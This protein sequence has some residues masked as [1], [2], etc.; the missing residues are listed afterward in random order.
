MASGQPISLVKFAGIREGKHILSKGALRWSSPELFQGPF[1]LRYDQGLEFSNKELLKQVLKT[2]A[3][4]VFARD[5]PTPG[6][7]D[8]PFSKLIRRWRTEDRFNS[9]EEVEE[10]LSNIVGNMVD[11]QLEETQELVQ[12]WSYLISH[13][14]VLSLLEKHQEIDFWEKYADN[15]RGIAIRFRCD[16]ENSSLANPQRAEYGVKRPQITTLKE[17][18]N[19]LIGQERKVEESTLHEKLLMRSKSK[20][21]EKE[22]VCHK[23]LTEAEFEEEQAAHGD[24]D[25][26]KWYQEVKFTA[27]E[28]SAVYFGQAVSDKDKKTILEFLGKNYPKAK[29]FEAQIHIEEYSLD[30]EPTPLIRP[31]KEPEATPEETSV[32]N[33]ATKVENPG[34]TKSS[35]AKPNTEKPSKTDSANDAENAQQ[36]KKPAP[37]S[38]AS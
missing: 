12:H 34:A 16:V 4:M 17:Q 2:I 14:R 27:K 3:A 29:A 23:T 35:A 19:V 31:V 30:F 37:E 21:H 5:M 1:E 24:I 15:H 11:K 36:G 6:L 18:V 32:E 25:A 10:A 20:I 26:K 33:T 8:H 22:W 7:P 38:K 28:L 13:T 9:E